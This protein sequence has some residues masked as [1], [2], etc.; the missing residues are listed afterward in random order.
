LN[1]RLSLEGQVLGRSEDP[2]VIGSDMIG[3]IFGK[4]VPPSEQLD[5]AIEL[6]D[7]LE[8]EK[9]AVPV[10]E[11]PP[12]ARVDETADASTD[13]DGDG[14]DSDLP[15]P[16]KIYLRQMGWSRLLSREGEVQIARQIEEA[17]GRLLAEAFSCSLALRYLIRLAERVESGEVRMSEVVA[18]LDEESETPEEEESRCREKF[19]ARIPRLKRIVTGMEKAARRARATRPRAK[20]APRDALSERRRAAL[21]A[22]V[23]SLRLTHRQIELAIE[24][25]RCTLQ[26]LDR[27]SAPIHAY[28]QATGRDLDEVLRLCRRLDH[29]VKGARRLL[30]MLPRR[31]KK[32]MVPGEDVRAA[33]RALVEGESAAGASADALRAM[34]QRIGEA[35]R[36]ANRAKEELIQANLRLVVSV[37]KRYTNRG[38]QLLDLIQEGNVGLMKAV[39]K[40]EYQRGYKFST[41][42]TWW[43]RQAMTRAIADQARTIRIPVHMIETISKLARV[44]RYLVQTLG[45]EPTPSELAEKMEIP[46]ERVEK[47]L[48]VVKQPVSLET[49][50]GEEEDGRLGDFIEDTQSLTPVDAAVSSSLCEQT[51]KA[52]ASLPPREEQVLRLRFGIDELTDHTLEE[53]GHRFAVTRERIRQI[54]A[55]ALRKLRHPSRS[56][57]LKGFLEG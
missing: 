17:N 31:W 46:I 40:F 20:R 6:L 37:A 10:A 41:Y 26:H 53:V 36:E 18:D 28:A 5:E 39:E 2:S 21:L 35:E 56:R 52:L 27:L 24:E 15:D 19:L 57:Y 11:A 12:E 48:R 47:V 29:G 51:R 34:L 13:A 4:D 22:T 42:A 1:R 3:E 32:A 9:D 44:S 25:M 16:L 43:I 55:K 7:D 45:R 30:G 23:R 49:P 38:L 8:W 33:A 50:V 14:Y 54:E